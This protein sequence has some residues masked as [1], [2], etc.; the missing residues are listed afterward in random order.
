ME[1]MITIKRCT[2]EYHK[3][4]RFKKEEVLGK[5]ILEMPIIANW[6]VEL[7]IQGYNR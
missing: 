6:I 1:Q 3:L 7:K 2:G 4:F 5:T